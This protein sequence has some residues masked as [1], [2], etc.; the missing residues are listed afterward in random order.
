MADG[1]AT[2]LPPTG[3][4]LTLAG[5]YRLVASIPAAR[6]ADTFLAFD[7]ALSRDVVVRMLPSP[8][9]ES[10]IAAARAI[11]HQ[12]IIRL[13]DSGRAAEL[14]GRQ[15]LVFEHA[16]GGTLADALLE[17]DAPPWEADRA[18][19]FAGDIAEAMA[20]VHGAGMAFGSLEADRIHLDGDG[21]PKVELRGLGTSTVP[22]A[23]IAPELTQGQATPAG[24]LYALGTVL[25][26]LLTGRAYVPGER[27]AG[28]VGLA[29]GAA[30][31]LVA[32]LAQ[33]PA[34]RPPSARAV[35]G[36]L[37]ALAIEARK[38]VVETTEVVEE[39]T[40][41][42][43]LGGLAVAFAI[44]VA[45]GAGAAYAITQDDDETTTP[46]VPTAPVPSSSTITSPAEATTD[47]VT[48]TAPE[49][50]D[51]TTETTTETATDTETTTE[52]ESATDATTG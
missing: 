8:A 43:S 52:T 23:L 7:L 32:L 48:P 44:L 3:P 33:D 14:S 45:A 11:D 13:L 46:V 27:I 5:R 39:R 12:G 36:R 50:T 6:G 30:G 24:D 26:L 10:E 28:P 42:S 31:L 35:A 16:S 22:G 34:R 49:G 21:R 19:A 40:R 20:A 29:H 41:P 37:R 2:N 9:L 38:L 15:F 4:P 25:H 1:D 47:V 51:V 17:R 18:L